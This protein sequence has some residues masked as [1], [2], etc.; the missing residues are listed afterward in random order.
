MFSHTSMPRSLLRGCLL[1]R[2]KSGIGGGL[3]LASILTVAAQVGPV[4]PPNPPPVVELPASFN[5]LYTFNPATNY[6]SFLG[7]TNL[8]GAFCTAS[9]IQG[10][11][12]RLYG[13]APSGGEFG[14]GT[15]FAL[16]TDGT[17]LTVLH[18]FTGV[19]YI[20]NPSRGIIPL[21]NAD[22]NT[23]TGLMLGLDG[24]LYGT[25]SKGGTNGF[26]AIFRLG[27]D[28]SGFTNLHSF[29]ASDGENPQGGL[30][31]GPEGTLYGTAENGGTNGSGTVFSLAP[32][33]SGFS[34]LYNFTALNSNTNA[35]GM[36]PCGGLILSSDGWLYGTAAFG[37]PSGT[38]RFI[39]QDPVGSGTIFKL[40]T[41]GACFTVLHAF[42]WFSN[43]L[44]QPTNSDGSSPQAALLFG[45]DGKLYGT[46][47][48]AGPGSAGTIFCL[49]TDGSEYTVLQAFCSIPFAPHL[50]SS[51]YGLYPRG[52][53][54]LGNDGLLYGAAYGGGLEGTYFAGTLYRLN[55]DGSGL[56]VLHTF[57]GLDPTGET[58]TDGANP[59]GTLLKASDGKFYGL[60][61]AG[62]T[63][64]SGTIFSFA[65]PVVLQV[66]ASNGSV[67]LS[68]PAS[69]T[70]FVLETSDA[71]SA[72]SVW[73]PLTSNI[74]MV[75][76]HFILF[77]AATNNTAF[78]R[79]HQP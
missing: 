69:A 44:I 24:N 78:F 10:R 3:F 67:M 79:L 36:R 60:T 73:T 75:S 72:G 8:E 31:Q 41:N 32:N 4:G 19:S 58:N 2:W 5:V 61:S 7:Y 43:E 21:S 76:N 65:P 59:S 45:P 68:W 55:L 50:N 62:G 13:V 30:V 46:A 26:G 11:D 15:V 18:A 35:D 49:G 48:E 38:I 6:V 34:V 29:A 64:G 1:C 57:A 17:G 25:T 70:N 66:S 52:G 33:D 42:D 22:G 56:A 39:S 63:N 47:P 23:A 9:L 71:L 12:G 37:G 14:G 40:M 74:S 20:G 53:L 28:G 77:L 51:G 27:C 16:N 54:V